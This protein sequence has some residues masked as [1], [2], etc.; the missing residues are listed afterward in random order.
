MTDNKMLTDH[1]RKPLQ[2]ELFRKFRAKLM[3]I[4]E[5]VEMNEMGWDRIETENSVSWKLHKESD[6]ACPQECV[7][8]YINMEK[9]T[10]ISGVL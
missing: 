1:F 8:N 10:T 4:S 3:N 7:G 6:P 5:D 2:E 9:G